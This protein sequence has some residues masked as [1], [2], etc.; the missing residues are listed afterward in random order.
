[1][2]INRQRGFTLTELMVGVSVMSILTVVGV[3]SMKD[4]IDNNQ[5]ATQSASL[6]KFMRFARSEAIKRRTSVVICKSSDGAS[7]AD[8]GDWNQGWLVF[9]DPN[10]NAL[11]DQTEEILRSNRDMASMSVSAKASEAIDDYVAFLSTGSARATDGSAQSGLLVM[12]DDRGFDDY[13]KALRLAQSGQIRLAKAADTG[14]NS[15]APP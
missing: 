4:T 14:A 6:Y 15:C 2:K 9:E 10:G 7:C 1:M 12:C 8:S 11:V 5:I 3:P 13:A